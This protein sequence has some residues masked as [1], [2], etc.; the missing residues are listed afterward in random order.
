MDVELNLFLP[1]GIAILLPQK[2]AAIVAWPRH[3]VCNGGM[4]PRR[5]LL[6]FAHPF[7]QAFHV[8]SLAIG[9]SIIAPASTYPTRLTHVQARLVFG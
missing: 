1:A 4:I 2:L 7:N 6:P 8:I 9:M 3:G 5:R